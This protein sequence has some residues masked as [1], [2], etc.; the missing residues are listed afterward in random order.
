[1]VFQPI[2]DIAEISAK[3]G[4]KHA[5]LSPG[6][7]CAPLTLA[8]VRHP[9]ITTKIIPDERSAA[10]IALGMALKLNT[11]VVLICTSGTAV[12]N[13]GPAI[14]EAFFQHIPLLVLTADR[15]AELIG[16]QDGQ[17]IYQ[18]EIF[19]RHVKMSYGFDGDYTHP[20]AASN[21]AQ[22]LLEAISLAS[23]FPAGPVHINIPFREPFYPDP[24]EHFSYS[25]NITFTKPQDND[26][27]L[28]QDELTNL[29]SQW[30][31]FKKILVLGGQGTISDELEKYLS[32]LASKIIVAG[33]II[34]NLHFL[35]EGINRLDIFTAYPD[36]EFIHQLKPDLLI[37]FG[38]S[39]VSKNLKLF[40]RNYMPAAHWHIQPQGQAAD[41]YQSVTHV[42][43]STPELFFKYAAGWVNKSV[44]DDVFKNAWISGESKAISLVDKFLKEV[45]FGEFVST[46]QVMKCLP[47]NAEV[48]L[49][50]SMP[51]R[52]A[53]LAGLSKDRN[54]L[55]IYS[56]RGTSGIDGSNSTA[57]GMAMVS[58]RPVVLITGDMSFFYDRNAFWHNHPVP[59]LYIVLLNNHA[60]GIFGLIDGPASQP[61]LNEYFET[62]QKLNA[63]NTAEEYEMDYFYANSTEKL[64]EALPRFFKASG[65]W[66][67]LE[68]ET[69]NESNKSI[70]RQFK[71]RIATTFT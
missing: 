51:V 30:R 64:R 32:T 10:F 62:L 38:D 35:K 7:R 11:P 60:G 47:A 42:V 19:G 41:T 50:N 55:V 69:D 2:N 58:D 36:N 6:S 70:F 3:R 8:F 22:T 21:I 63:Q 14:A 59:N 65:R 18:E 4:I 39:T 40:L 33:D 29:E 15:P 13:Y 37:T 57:T 53:N 66:R 28:T 26:Y 68:I 17:T 16:R 61:E 54:D 56:N 67:I 9:E 1:M 12:L 23:E 27:I 43:R 52:L 24:D 45:S 49:A 20:E 46:Q 71:N 25:E 31:S 48:H 5:V 44:V 34:S